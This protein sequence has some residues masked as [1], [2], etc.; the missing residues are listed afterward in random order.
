MKKGIV[1]CVGEPVCRFTED[2]LR[3]LRAV[4]FSA[5]LGFSIEKDTRQAAQTLAA[6]LSK[7]S[8]ERVQVELT[9]L[10][11]SDHPEKIRLVYDMGLAPYI[12][13]GFCQ[14]R[15]RCLV[16]LDRLSKTAPEKHVRWA[17]FLRF[18][19]PELA[20]GILRDLKMDN[21]TIDKVKTLIFAAKE[22]LRPEKPEIRRVMSRLSSKLYQDL[23]DIWEI[24][25]REEERERLRQIRRLSE[26]IIE[27]GDCICLKNLAVSGKDLIEAGRKPGPELGKTLNYLFQL[28][29]DHPEYNTK[30]YLMKAVGDER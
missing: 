8:R 21:D 12:T 6:N 25:G 16:N 7:V 19:K 29:L 13:E 5:Q 26:Q 10:L 24:Y 18:E 30:E 14:A 27:D 11:L 2:A 3:I 17:A 4:R 9:K 15:E 23:L 1:R 22:K 28:V 20:A